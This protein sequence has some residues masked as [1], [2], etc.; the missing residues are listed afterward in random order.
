LL[1][2][3]GGRLVLVVLP[4]RACGGLGFPRS[5]KVRRLAGCAL[6]GGW[7]CLCRPGAVKS[8]LFDGTRAVS[9]LGWRGWE[10][11]PDRRRPFSFGL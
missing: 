8:P 4:V 6:V 3:D 10:P 11:T 1:P 5:R 2:T 9:M 7:V